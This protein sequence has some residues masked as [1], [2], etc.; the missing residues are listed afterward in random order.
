MAVVRA[1][2]IVLGMIVAMQGVVRA[3]IVLDLSQRIQF[4]GATLAWLFGA[5][6]VNDVVLLVLFALP[7]MLLAALLPR[8]A[9]CRAAL[10]LVIGLI[11]STTLLAAAADVFFWLDSGTRADAFVCCAVPLPDAWLTLWRDPWLRAGTGMGVAA[12][13][14]VA[15]RASR[16]VADALL[17]APRSHCVGAAA[18]SLLLLGVAMERDGE[19]W[20]L[21]ADESARLDYAVSSG[22]LRLAHT[23]SIGRDRGASRF[24]PMNPIAAAT[25][26]GAAFGRSST[27]YDDEARHLL[28]IA[29]APDAVWRRPRHGDDEALRAIRSQGVYYDQ[30]YATGFGMR[31]MVDGV[32]RGLPPLPG[33][34][35]DL[36]SATEQSPSLPRVLSDAGFT[37][38]LVN[39]AATAALFDA[40]QWRALGGT[41]AV[42]SDEPPLDSLLHTMDLVAGDSPRVF[43]FALVESAAT[44]PRFVDLAAQSPWFDDTLIVVV[45]SPSP[46]SVGA[47]LIPLQSLRVPAVL[48]WPGRLR[49]R[50]ARHVS[51]TLD[52]AR[53]ALRVLGVDSTASFFGR[54]LFG[55]GG[56]NAVNVA[57]VEYG[58]RAGIVTPAGLTV[59]MRAAPPRFWRLGKRTDELGGTDAQ[60][61]QL[62]NAI[63]A[64]TE[65]VAAGQ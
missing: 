34:Q 23:L 25:L 61:A 55:I 37:S 12:L 29:T 45:A 58:G 10:A 4:D 51:S 18:V 27:H 36:T 52:I 40:A 59:L 16:G 3:L 2:G 47:A 65:Q 50:V 49:P 38:L 30:M 54:D 44:V 9:V 7:L 22:A 26:L 43:A 64:A 41:R 56:A 31:R 1:L 21:Q 46:R 5:G 62:A 60:V 35:P 17:D 15:T 32:L 33:M 11:V 6:M 42:Q 53:T 19:L 39:S 20:M 28:V 14:I 13:V 24:T 57:P 48:I 63:Y 8:R